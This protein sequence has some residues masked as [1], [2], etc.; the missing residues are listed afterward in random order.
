M[1][2]QGDDDIHGDGSF[3][4]WQESA[5]SLSHLCLACLKNKTRPVNFVASHQKTGV[6]GV[7]AAEPH[8][9]AG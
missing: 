6:S 8:R 9:A 2:Q 7:I 3:G 1:V 4:D 5:E